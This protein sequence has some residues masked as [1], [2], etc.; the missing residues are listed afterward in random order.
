M[1]DYDELISVHKVDVGF[2]DVS[3]M[4]HLEMLLTRSKIAQVETHLTDEQRAALR[5]R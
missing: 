5:S 2:P 4:E 1:T 3:S